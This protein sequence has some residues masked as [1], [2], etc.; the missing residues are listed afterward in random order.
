M[1]TGDDIMKLALERRRALDVLAKASAALSPDERDAVLVTAERL[2]KQVPHSEPQ[3]TRKGNTM[4]KK[5]ELE[6][7]LAKAEEMLKERVHNGGANA[8]LAEEML[9]HIGAP[10]R[11]PVSVDAS[12]R[13]MKTAA[14]E[15]DRMGDYNKALG[16]RQ[17]V[18]ELKLQIQERARNGRN[19]SRMGPGSVE[20]FKNVGTLPEDVKLGGI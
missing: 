4:G 16:L 14:D 1:T 17:E 13:L 6:A 8:A 19:F 3:P 18:A 11:S 9:G 15:A 7:R 20:L 10:S 5:K 12:I 2:V